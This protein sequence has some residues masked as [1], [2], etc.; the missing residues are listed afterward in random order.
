MRVLFPYWDWIG[1]NILFNSQYN[2]GEGVI[3]YMEF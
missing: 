1:P 3:R 2:P